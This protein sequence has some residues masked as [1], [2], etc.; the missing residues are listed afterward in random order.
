MKKVQRYKGTKAKS[1]LDRINRIIEKSVE[2]QRGRVEIA[3]SLA[4]LTPRNDVVVSNADCG[5]KVD[6]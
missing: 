2:M 5:M 1:V 6:G 3:S 4:S